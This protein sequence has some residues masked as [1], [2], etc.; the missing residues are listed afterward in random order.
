MEDRFGDAVCFVLVVA[1]LLMPN[2]D[3]R[4]DVVQ[5][6]SKTQV[7]LFGCVLQLRRIGDWSSPRGLGTSC[8]LFR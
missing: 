2:K 6:E 7:S 4:I 3:G 1:G 5:C 8:I